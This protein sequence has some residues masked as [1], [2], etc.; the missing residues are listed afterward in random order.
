L[1]TGKIKA[2]AKKGDRAAI[3]VEKKRK[4]AI[5]GLKG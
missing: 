3:S 1:Q 5:K 4:T 2:L